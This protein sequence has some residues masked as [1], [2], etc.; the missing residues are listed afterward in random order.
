VAAQNGRALTGL[1]VRFFPFTLE[2]YPFRFRDSLTGK[3]IRARHKLQVPE[4]QCHYSEWEITG[5]P[6]VTF[7]TRYE[8]RPPI[9]RLNAAPQAM[10]I[11]SQTAR[12]SV[13]TPI[14]APMPAPIAMLVPRGG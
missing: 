10:P 6:A 3:W 14:A 11:A 5:P 13:A 2:L 8:P 1:S 12:L 4:I 9:E 7:T